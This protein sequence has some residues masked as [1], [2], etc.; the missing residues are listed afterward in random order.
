[1]L[2]G[3]LL[4]LRLLVVHILYQPSTCRKNVSH[5]TKSESQRLE[6]AL[7]KMIDSGRFVDLANFHGA[8]TTIC[9]TTLFFQTVGVVCCPH[10]V[11][12]FLP[13]H[14]LYMVQMEEELGMAL[15]F[16]DWT[17]TDHQPNLWSDIDA[18]I[19]QGASSVCNQPEISSINKDAKVNSAILRNEIRIA[20]ETTNYHDFWRAVV[21]P[22]NR[23][24]HNLGC[25]MSTANTA[26]YVPFFFLHHSF[27]DY[28]WAYWQELQRLRGHS[29][30]EDLDDHLQPFNRAE[31]N[32]HKR[33]LK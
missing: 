16:W 30:N 4:S 25:D 21:N 5:L 17:M 31:Y 23:I 24:H 10:G 6:A 28:V 7:K 33:T 22:H 15:P 29:V 27:V 11:S 13:W 19:K 3:R 1:M 8:P 2:T 12:V 20:L 32:R 14:R 18:P 9:E 26:S